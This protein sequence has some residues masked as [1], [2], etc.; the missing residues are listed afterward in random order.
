MCQYVTS[1]S[2]LPGFGDWTIHSRRAVPRLRCTGLGY[3]RLIITCLHHTKQPA[4]A[5]QP[6]PTLSPQ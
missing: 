1:M 5:T 3:L 6:H 4:Q 2:N